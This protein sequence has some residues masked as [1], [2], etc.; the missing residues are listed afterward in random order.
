KK[1]SNGL[2]NV[3]SPVINMESDLDKASKLIGN[4]VKDVYYMTSNDLFISLLFCLPV[5]TI[6]SK[7]SFIFS[8]DFTVLSTL[9]LL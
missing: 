4:M 1:V 6:T 9:K 2:S 3:I 7:F 8:S 5:S